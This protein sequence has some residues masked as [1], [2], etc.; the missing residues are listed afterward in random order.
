MEK[1]TPTAT[2]IARFNL[3]AGLGQ[4]SVIVASDTTFELRYHRFSGDTGQ[5]GE[6]ETWLVI[7]PDIVA[8]RD[9]AQAQRDQWQARTDTLNAVLAYLDSVRGG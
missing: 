2:N 5:R 7:Y 6:D 1:W 3:K 8:E 4:A 9:V